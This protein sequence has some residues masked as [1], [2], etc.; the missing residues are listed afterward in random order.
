MSLVSPFSPKLRYLKRVFRLTRSAWQK[1]F[2]GKFDDKAFVL[3]IF[4]AHIEKVKN[5]V[6]KEKLLIYEVK[7]GWQPLCTFLGM[8]VPS[9][10]FPKLN[11]RATFNTRSK[12][13]VKSFL[14]GFKES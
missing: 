4:N 12:G 7:E 14:K 6:P 3:E 9:T 11:N 1:D 10:P 13:G 8:P 5:T 2:L